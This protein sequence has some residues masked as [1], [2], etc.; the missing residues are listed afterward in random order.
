MGKTERVRVVEMHPSVKKF[1]SDREGV[2]RTLVEGL[3]QLKNDRILDSNPHL[4]WDFAQGG[5]DPKK[6]AD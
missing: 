4:I 5:L 1:L 3:H 2:F 6:I